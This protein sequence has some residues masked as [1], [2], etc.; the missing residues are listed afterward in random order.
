VIAVANMVQDLADDTVLGEECEDLDPGSTL[1]REGVEL[2]DPGQHP[3]P[4]QTQAA[5][6]GWRRLAFRTLRTR[7]RPSVDTGVY[8]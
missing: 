5:P 6:P 2:G 8:P 4:A 1:T 7:P 3:G